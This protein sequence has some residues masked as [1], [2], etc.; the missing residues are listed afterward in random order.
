MAPVGTLYAP[1]TKVLNSNQQTPIMTPT[2]IAIEMVSD[3]L[4]EN[5]FFIEEF[6]AFE[7]K[8]EK[9]WERRNEWE[10]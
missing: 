3:R 4:L 8:I 2:L 10:D 1:K 5:P 7:L 6:I 9:K